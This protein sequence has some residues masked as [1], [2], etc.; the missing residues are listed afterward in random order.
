M[1]PWSTFT[2]ATSVPP[3]ESNVTVY[4]LISHFA[5]NLRSLLTDKLNIYGVVFASLVNQP[6]N[7]YPTLVGSVGS[8]NFSP[9]ITFTASI[10]FP[11]SVSK[12]TV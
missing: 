6:T 11:P 4:S 8:T 10:V 12:V 2:S 7:V 9:S 1:L 3:L 5:Y